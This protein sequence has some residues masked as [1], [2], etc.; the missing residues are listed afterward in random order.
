MTT[1]RDPHRTSAQAPLAATGRLGRSVFVA[2]VAAIGGF[3]FGYDSA[4]INGAV[5]GIQHHFHVSS[6][7]TGTVVAVALLGSA[8][9]AAA[10]GRLAD[11]FGRLR[12][13]HLAAALFAV[14][15]LGSGLSGAVWQLAL[16]RLLGGIAIGMSSVIG[17][18]YIAEIAP[19]AYR[20]RLASFQQAAIVLGITA[21][22]LVNWAIAQG[23]GGRSEDSL[24]PLDAWQWMLL[25]AVV[26]AVLYFVL[27]SRI[28][29][30]PHYLVAVG[31]TDDA[32]RAVLEVEGA[33]SDVDTRVAE[34]E[35]AV[36]TARK[37]RI[38]DL[39]GGA[40]GLLP[41]VWAGIGLAVFQQLV[42]INVIF[43]YSSILWQSVG[44]DQSS[45]L[46][47]SLST[48]VINIIGT[49]VAM[50]FIDRIGR[51]PLALIGSAGM[52]VSLGLA[53]WAFSYKTGVG[54]GI[55][56]PQAQGVVAL[57][58]AHSFVLFF[59]V[60]WG[61]ILWVMVGEMFPFR[62]RA[63][64]ISVATAFNWIANWAVTESF[65]SMAK[66]N[67]S[68]TYAIY[69]GCAVLSG[70]FVV[71]VVSETKGQRLESVS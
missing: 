59:A 25:A 39:F 20:G 5:L 58:A 61:V 19:A 42:G 29:E 8:V 47:I 15:A 65:P 9:G 68:A 46:L 2:A 14:S 37:P 13:M 69:A 31:R 28:P 57:I 67:L 10:A 66:W 60:S 63:A 49:L 48:S 27:T 45:S 44:I 36:R 50:M 62:I 43:Y 64:A 40:F 4:V 70:V 23:A 26:P 22:Q 56:I 52:A 33:D 30:S 17:P 11:R 35:N 18:T 32:R 6:G 34:I 38:G 7:E 51:K 55:S 53:A 21:S 12:V 24:G 16:W 71:K 1:S 41:I 54:T 3:L